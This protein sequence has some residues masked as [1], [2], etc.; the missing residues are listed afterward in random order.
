[1][2]AANNPGSPNTTTTT[3]VV[4]RWWW[5]YCSMTRV[6]TKERV[7]GRVFHGNQGIRRHASVVGCMHF[8]SD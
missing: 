6:F 5:W 1:M 8:Y 2:Y 7:G 4:G 3:K